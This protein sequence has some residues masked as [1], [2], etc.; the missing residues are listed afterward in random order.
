MASAF[1]LAD[2]ATERL[3]P[4]TRL[5]TVAARPDHRPVRARLHG[6]G[7]ARVQVRAPPRPLRRARAGV[8]DGV[9]ARR[10]AGDADAPSADRRVGI[11]LAGAH[12]PARS[13]P[14]SHKPPKTAAEPS[15]EPR[16]SD[17]LAC[18]VNGASILRVCGGARCS[19][20]RAR[21]CWP[22]SW[23]GG[24]GTAQRTADG[25]SLTGWQALTDLRWLLLV[26]IVAAVALVFAQVTRRAPAIP[27]TMSLIVMLLGHRDR[28][29][30]DLPRPDQRRPAPAGRRL[31]G[32]AVRDRD[33][34]RWLPLAAP[35]GH[36]PAGRADGTSRSCGRGASIES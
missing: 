25:G 35:G 28:G 15:P 10:G 29:G 36:R 4:Q 3:S 6:R 23:S 27:V 31:P 11:G 14:E 12:R 33:R 17:R 19:R 24:S 7:I 21:C 5:P 26:T 18:A 13:G 20:A 30:A 9:A 1:L 22:S 16:A 8:L 2:L 34:V 32:P